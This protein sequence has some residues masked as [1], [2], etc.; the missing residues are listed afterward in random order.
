M[1]LIERHRS[2]GGGAGDVSVRKAEFEVLNVVAGTRGRDDPDSPFLAEALAR[3]S[4]DP[5]VKPALRNIERVVLVHR[6]REVFPGTPVHVT[7]YCFR[8]TG[9]KA[10]GNGEIGG[11][12]IGQCRYWNCADDECKDDEKR[13]AEQAAK[14]SEQCK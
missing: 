9:I 10:G 4:W 2:G 7:K 11:P 14:V 6:L 13:Y 3:A 8:S 1:A 5:D 12:L